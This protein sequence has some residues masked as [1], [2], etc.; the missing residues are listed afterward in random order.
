MK[1]VENR[2]AELVAAAMIDPLRPYRDSAY[3]YVETKAHHEKVVRALE[4]DC[5]FAHPYSSL[6][7]GL[8]E[9]TNGLIRQHIAE[10]GALKWSQRV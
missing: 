4:C 5:Y 6:G 2:T 10:G 3:Y 7:R 8:N 9:N 1:K